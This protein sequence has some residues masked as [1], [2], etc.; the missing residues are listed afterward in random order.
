[1]KLDEL[2]RSLQL[3]QERGR[4]DIGIYELIRLHSDFPRYDRRVK[5]TQRVV[6]GVV[7]AKRE[8]GLKASEMRRPF[9]EEIW[10]EA[11]DALLEKRAKQ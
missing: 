3:I 4:E 6:S 11:R 9:F 1:M 10:P 2:I 8:L 5:E 7:R